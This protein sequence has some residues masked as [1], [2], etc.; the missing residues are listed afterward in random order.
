MASEYKYFLTSITYIIFLFTII[1][2]LLYVKR[3]LS[4]IFLWTFHIY[5]FIGLAGI[6]FIDACK[7]K[8]LQL[9]PKSIYIFGF[10]S[11]E[12][13]SYVMHLS[14]VIVPLHILYMKKYENELDCYHMYSKQNIL[15]SVLVFTVL[16]V[17]YSIYLYP[18]NI[19]EKYIRSE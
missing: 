5:I 11:N 12:F 6:I 7:G 3:G 2:E 8:I 1:I 14:L 15:Y 13:L 10:R 19:V 4:K 16:L 18:S 17:S 9:S